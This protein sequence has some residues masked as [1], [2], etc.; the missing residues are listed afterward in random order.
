MFTR[1]GANILFGFAILCSILLL[2][3]GPKLRFDY[4]F[5]QFFPDSDAD[6]TFY[7]EFSKTFGT[8]ND[9]LLLAF[10]K[11][12]E[13][14]LSDFLINL[15]TLQEDLESSAQVNTVLSVWDIQ[16]PV[17]GLFGLRVI[18]AL[19]VKEGAV[20][21]NIN[22]NDLKGTFSSKTGDSWLLLVKNRAGISKEEGDL[23]Y[24]KIRGHIESSPLHLKAVAG[25]IQTQG[26][27]VVLMQQEFGMFFALSLILMLGLLI[28]VFRTWWG[29]LIPVL[30]L[31]IGVL[32]AFALILGIG[33]SL[34]LMS[35]MQ[36]TI[37][38]VVGLSALVH[39]FT[40]FQKKRKLGL[41][42]EQAVR[43]SF[44]ELFVPVSLT[45]L[46]TALGFLS[47]YFTTI[48]ALKDFGLTTGIGILAVFAAVLG[49]APFLLYR[50]GKSTKTKYS[51]SSAEIGMAPFFIWIVG[52]RR[53]IPWAFLS[54]SVFGIWAGNQ[55]PVNGFLLDNLPE[56]HPIQQDFIFFDEEF[57]GSNPIEIY[58][59]TGL[60]S[61]SLV[62]YEVLQQ[63]ETVEHK[64]QELFPKA[65]FISPITLVKALNQAQNQGS[66][67][68]FTFPSQGQFLR[69]KS[70]LGRFIDR[71]GKE[72]L[73]LD[74]KEGRIGGRIPDLGTLE[75]ER[76][77]AEFFS[78]LENEV[79]QDLLQVRWT[80]TSY[81]I[82][83]GHQTVTLQMARGLGV[84]FLLVGLIAGVLFRSWRISFILLI[85]NV[86]PL[87]WML[88]V[89][90]LLGVEFKLTTAI[91]FTVAF[92]IAVDDSI[93]FMTR[94][95]LE[96]SKGKSLFYALKRTFLETGKALIWTTVILVAGFSLFLFSRFGVTYY[97]G[98]LIGTS[99][100]FALVA[101]QI[102]LPIMLMPMKK[103]WEKKQEK[104]AYSGN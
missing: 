53:W 75:M 16:K 97:S 50:L 87:L 68:A 81:L 3:L 45:V 69:M 48:P 96:M 88:G 77:R 99:L 28:A 72:V 85:P 1:S 42:H 17:I 7:R 10:E 90:Y 91:L 9:Y 43:E 89:M 47:L 23:L 31:G 39:I 64:L 25:K 63:I 34:A 6:L 15:K 44:Q 82:D 55:I 52:N 18:P 61:S 30:V 71:S 67:R 100:I 103:V 37:F 83:Q 102:L 80:G 73:T 54:L 19:E 20:N 14:G 41:A 2:S 29:V 86:V 51:F 78:F 27:F 95:R 21:W 32:W 101:D 26:D 62:E 60:N 35:V 59:K 12:D 22:P 49:F 98:L 58:L 8:D 70:Y 36:P 104:K 92:G 5:E 93:H 13:E 74:R 79:D 46:T 33:K 66:E 4:D 40:H 94:L 38:L 11:R 24:Q 84:A 76:K 57:G 56:D 65:E